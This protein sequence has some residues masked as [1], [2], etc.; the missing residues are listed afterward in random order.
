MS[1]WASIKPLNAPRMSLADPKIRV[2]ASTVDEMFHHSLMKVL[3]P[4][5][6]IKIEFARQRARR[7]G[8]F[9][10]DLEKGHDPIVLLCQKLETRIGTIQSL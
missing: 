2:P 8:S 5:T 4:S 9:R 7:D 6:Y 10:L 1:R 3:E